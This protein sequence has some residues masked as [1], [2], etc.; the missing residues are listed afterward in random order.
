MVRRVVI[1]LVISMAVLRGKVQAQGEEAQ[2]LLLNVAKL[3]QMKQ[4]LEQVKEGYE[5]ISKGYLAVRNISEGSF[6]LH[7]VFMDGLLEVSPVVRNY[8]KVSEIIQGQLRLIKLC[9]QTLAGVKGTDLLQEGELDYLSSVLDNTL[10]RSLRQIE[11]LAMVMTSRSLRMSDEERLQAI[12]RIRAETGELQ[13]FLKSFAAEA[14]VLLL[15]RSR[16]Q[17]DNTTIRR[18]HGK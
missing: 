3:A 1:C 11:E 14:K 17:H 13:V 2:Q 9:K 16:E 4:I 10:K 8:Y 12:D 7:R 15:Q 18:I 5:I 6:D